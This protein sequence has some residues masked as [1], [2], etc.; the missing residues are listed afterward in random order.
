M[1][2]GDLQKKDIKDDRDFGESGGGRCGQGG[3]WE[4]GDIKRNKGS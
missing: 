3:L 1:I 4:E 2:I